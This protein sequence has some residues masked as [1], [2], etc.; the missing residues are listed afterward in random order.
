MILLVPNN[1]ICPGKTTQFPVTTIN[2]VL[3]IKSGDPEYTVVGI[4]GFII[5]S[6]NK[7]NG[8]FKKFEYIAEM[9]G[10]EISVEAINR[11]FSENEIRLIKDFSEVMACGFYTFIWPENFPEG[12]E[13]TSKQIHSYTF[14]FADDL[15]VHTH[16]L[17]SMTELE[18]GIAK[19][20]GGPFSF[21]K[22]MRSASSNVECHLANHTKNPWPG[23][24][25]ALIYNHVQKKYIAIIEFKTHNKDE[26]IGQEHIGKYG[27]ED[28]RRFN[29]LFDLTDNFNHKLGYRPKLFF[30]V[31]GT[32]EGLEN[33]ADLKIDLLERN[34]VVKSWLLPR[35]PYNQFSD[36]LFRF[37]LKKSN[38]TTV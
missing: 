11:V 25:D 26:Q 33:H 36:E 34:T 15:K 10:E 19:L 3:W 37:I 20:R 2:P 17:I 38:E 27:Q 30:I 29:V 9:P 14:D 21:V 18:S 4:D 16:K 12:Y 32:N 1:R 23:D 13:L 35:P 5:N 8:L 22:N 7:V 28:W 24:I 31:W 6:E